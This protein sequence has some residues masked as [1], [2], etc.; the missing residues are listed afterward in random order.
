MSGG[1]QA[2]TEHPEGR[3][4]SFGWLVLSVQTVGYVLSMKQ[5]SCSTAFLSKYCGMDIRVLGAGIDIRC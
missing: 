2:M 5:E 3:L 4:S 1:A